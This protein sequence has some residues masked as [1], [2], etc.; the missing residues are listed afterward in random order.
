[1]TIIIIIIIVIIIIISHGKKWSSSL[2]H[3]VYTVVMG[4]D[5]FSLLFYISCTVERSVKC[6]LV[7]SGTECTEVMGVDC[8]KCNE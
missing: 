4:V 5:I 7:H 6:G 3:W 8:N 1:M 2:R